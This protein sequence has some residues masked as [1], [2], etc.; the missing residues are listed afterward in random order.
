MYVLT[1]L[2]MCLASYTQVFILW[3]QAVSEGI[4]CSAICE[5]ANFCVIIELWGCSEPIRRAS[6]VF[7]LKLM[8]FYL[9]L[10]AFFLISEMLWYA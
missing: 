9:L 6:F 8:L 3:V 7:L 1:Y 2:S 10:Y 5:D 4:I